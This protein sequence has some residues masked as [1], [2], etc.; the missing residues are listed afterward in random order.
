MHPQLSL[1]HIR[2]IYDNFLFPGIR[3]NSPLITSYFIY[4]YHYRNNIP[5]CEPA[6]K[7]AAP[8]SPRA[9]GWYS[10]CAMQL[11]RRNYGLL[12][13]Q[14][15][16]PDIQ[17]A[18]GSKCNFKA[19]RRADQLRHASLG[20]AKVLYSERDSGLGAFAFF[21]L[22]YAHMKGYW[23]RGIASALGMT[24]VVQPFKSPAPSYKKY[25]LSGEKRFGNHS[26]Q[27]T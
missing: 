25:F 5:M 16:L 12:L 18:Y 11:P 10:I 27:K 24:G 6:N 3:F 8:A 23:R 21:Q 4:S 13:R 15:Y 14:L 26:T 7:R 19:S 9:A 2:R 20:V 1:H 17:L 22:Q